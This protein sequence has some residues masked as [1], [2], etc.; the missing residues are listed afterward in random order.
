MKT[1]ELTAKQKDEI[2][3]KVMALSPQ[4]QKDLLLLLSGYVVAREGVEVFNKLMAASVMTS[5]MFDS[6]Q[7]ERN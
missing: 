1:P 4:Y 3:E 6:R 5:G 7:A 2:R